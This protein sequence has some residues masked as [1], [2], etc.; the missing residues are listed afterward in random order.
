MYF[1]LSIVGKSEYSVGSYSPR[2][3]PYNYETPLK[4]AP[5]GLTKRG[6]YT[7]KSKFMDEHMNIYLEW[8]WAYD[9]KKEW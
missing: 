2:K 3:E 5:S 9:I 7:V 6:H 4:N 1:A 8:E